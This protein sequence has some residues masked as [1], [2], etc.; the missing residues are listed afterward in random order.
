VLSAILFNGCSSVPRTN[1]Q[2]AISIA[3]E[4]V[5]KHG[6]KRF[7]VHSSSFVNERW[8]VAII[9]KPTKVVGCDAVVQMSIFLNL[10]WCSTIPQRSNLCAILPDS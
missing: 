9:R 8:V 4:E 1:E 3:K 5:R 2:L 7:E 6:W 10:D